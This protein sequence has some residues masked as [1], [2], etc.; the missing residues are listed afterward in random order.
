MKRSTTIVFS[1]V[2]PAA[3]LALLLVPAGCNPI[4]CFRASEAGGV[5]PSQDEALPYFGDPV[6]GGVVA[7]VDSPPGLRNGTAEE[8][9][10]CCY[11][12]TN[13]APDYSGCPDF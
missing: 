4:G 13:Q 6:C 1:V 3:A 9:P 8:G 5:C 10:L 7:S 2:P 12:I 11:A